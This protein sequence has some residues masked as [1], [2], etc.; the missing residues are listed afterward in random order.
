MNNNFLEIR[1]LV[2][3]ALHLGDLSEVSSIARCEDYLAQNLDIFVK[4]GIS[5]V[6][7]QD[8]TPNS[9]FA[10]PETIALMASLG[11]FARTEFPQVQLG[12]IF[13]SHDSHAPIAVAYAC[14][15]AF[16]RIKVFVGAMLKAD[17]IQQGCGIDAINYRQNLAKP[18][19]KILA[20]V[21]DRTGI[22]LMNVPIEVAAQ[23]AAKTGADGLVLTGFNFEQ[24]LEYVIA[25]RKSKIETP[26]LVGGGVNESNLPRVLKYADGV[27]VSTSLKRKNNSPE[28]IVQ[29]DLEKIKRFMHAANLEVNKV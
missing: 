16:V 9:S 28:D 6:M 11:R 24:S 21:H 4:G 19:I 3:G 29:W 20:D 23:W 15:A 17:G 26:L 25:V 10:R 8:G 12:I 2:I 1:P 22:P 14:G 7:I 27:I 18:N 13:R 5:A